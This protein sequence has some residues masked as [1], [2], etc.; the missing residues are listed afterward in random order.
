MGGMVGKKLEGKLIA[1]DY[2]A[3]EPDYCRKAWGL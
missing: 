3:R 1:V 2:G